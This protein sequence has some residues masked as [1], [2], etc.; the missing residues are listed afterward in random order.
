MIELA[1]PVFDPSQLRFRR[2]VVRDLD[3][4]NQNGI[5]AEG[6]ENYVVNAV[7]L[8]PDFLATI[9]D[10]ENAVEAFRGARIERA[11]HRFPV[12]EISK[13]TGECTSLGCIIIQKFRRALVLAN[14]N[15]P[16]VRCDRNDAVIPDLMDVIGG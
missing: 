15:V 11:Q 12:D 5:I 9:S 6:R 13:T 8:V 14:T 10:P 3:L 4:R 1:A 16:V 7:A 2:P